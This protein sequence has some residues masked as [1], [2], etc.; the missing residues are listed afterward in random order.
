MHFP[1]TIYIPIQDSQGS[2]DY[3]SDLLGYEPSSLAGGCGYIPP[4]C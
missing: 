3:D 1:G 2:E 4:K